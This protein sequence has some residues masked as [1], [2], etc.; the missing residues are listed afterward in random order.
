MSNRLR[1]GAT[2]TEFVLTLPPI[3]L[4]TTGIYDLTSMISVENAVVQ[5]AR[6]GARLGAATT[7]IGTVAATES[8][9]EGLAV[10]HATNVLDDS[11]FP[12]SSGCVVTADYYYAASG[13]AYVAVDVEYPFVPLIGFVPGLERNVNHQIVMLAQKQ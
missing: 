10:D 5:A 9:I 4:L 8:D 2:L 11:G 7:K 1:R 3:L 12:C 13:Y 6:D